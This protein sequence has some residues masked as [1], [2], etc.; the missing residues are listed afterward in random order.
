MGRVRVRVMGRVRVRVRVRVKPSITNQR[1]LARAIRVWSIPP[2]TVDSH[3]IV[4]MDSELQIPSS[5]EAAR[6]SEGLVWGW[7]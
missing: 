5:E 3:T 4:R 6:G 1:E 7:D 2:L